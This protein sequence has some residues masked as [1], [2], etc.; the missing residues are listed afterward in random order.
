MGNHLVP[1]LMENRSHLDVL[2]RFSSPD[3]L[4]S[5]EKLGV[6]VYNV[7]LS[8]EDGFKDVPGEYDWACNM[9]KVKF[10]SGPNHR[11]TVE[12][13]VMAIGRIMEHFAGSGGIMYAS[14]VKHGVP[15][16][17]MEH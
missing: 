5:F 14:N 13:Q 6:G 11:C 10:R 7:D 3:I 16:S 9:E 15:S 17:S 8:L 4:K 2:A 1:K 12:L